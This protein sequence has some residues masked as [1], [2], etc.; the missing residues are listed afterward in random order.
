MSKIKVVIIISSLVILAA[1][2]GVLYYVKYHHENINKRLPITAHHVATHNQENI[3]YVLWHDYLE[4][5]ETTR[6]PFKKLNARYL[7]FEG[8]KKQANSFSIDIVFTVKLQSKKWS[9]H[10]NWGK[11]NEN[12]EIKNLRWHLTVKKTGAAS[13]RLEQIRPIKA[14]ASSKAKQPTSDL[15]DNDLKTNEK[16][17][18]TI[19]RQHLQVT[20]DH[21]KRWLNVPVSIDE[22]F[23]GDYSGPKDTLINGSYVITP[24][25]TAFVVGEGPLLSILQS[26]DQG[27]TWKRYNVG[28]PFPGVRLR[29]LGFTSSQEGYLIISGDRTMHQEGNSVL[30]THDGGQSWAVAGAVPVTYMLSDGGFINDKLGFMSF[31]SRG[32]PA[33]PVFYRTLDGGKTWSEV[34]IPIPA[35]FSGIFT[36]AEVPTF[37][38]TKGTL[39]VNQGD[40]G[41][42]Q[43]G[44]VLAQFTS[45]DQGATWTFEKVVEPEASNAG[46]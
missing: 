28:S 15:P 20:Y 22:L 27:K 26:T 31:G 36:E 5:Y 23:K 39:L 19:Y 3:A 40:M 37:K 14:S 6:N 17:A 10:R 33:H 7:R 16:N 38:G 32:N 25:R 42:Y 21:G 41:D 9:T 2:S 35:K 45:N 29:F 4:P 43:G 12:G 8:L 13:Y 46:E 34:H 18:Y 11:V 44:D 24:E 1:A 30:K